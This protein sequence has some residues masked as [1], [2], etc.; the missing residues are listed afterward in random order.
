MITP[1]TVYDYDMENNKL[2]VLKVQEVKNYKKEDYLSKRIFV[3]A[4]DGTRIPVSLFFKKQ[5]NLD[6]KNPLILYGYGGYGLSTEPGF[7]PYAVSLVERG[8][9]YAIAHV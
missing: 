2:E 1:T 5:L 4:R 7:L 3:T 6:G 9:I 8:F